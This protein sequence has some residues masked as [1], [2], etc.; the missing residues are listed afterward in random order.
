MEEGW[1]ILLSPEPLT[2]EDVRTYALARGG[3]L[4][5]LSARLL[6]GGEAAADEA[7]EAWA[8]ADLA[9]HSNEADAD[10]AMAILRS[11]PRPARIPTALRPLGMLAALAHR[12]A[13]PGRRRW[14]PQGAPGRMWRMLRHRLTGL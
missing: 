10:S 4:F 2:Q 11:R 8:L 7:G 12:D 1:A 5:R 13:E 9:R 3:R 6:G 14:E